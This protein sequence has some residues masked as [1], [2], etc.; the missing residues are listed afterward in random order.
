MST[1]SVEAAEPKKKKLADPISDSIKER[2]DYGS[3]LSVVKAAK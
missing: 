1:V 3:Y 2:K